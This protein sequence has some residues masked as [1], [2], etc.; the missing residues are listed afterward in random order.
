MTTKRKRSAGFGAGWILAVCFAARGAAADAEFFETRIRPVLAE[1]CYECHS[2]SAS[3]LKGGLRVDA[4]RELLKGGN[5]GPAVVPGE[6]KASLLL[7]SIEHRDADLAMPPKKPKLS[8]ATLADFER[9]IR[10]GAKWP[11]ST[12]GGESSPANSAKK[13][14]F[15]LE[16][17]KQKQAWL[18]R[19]P[20]APAIPAVQNSQWPR[21]P[22]D[23]FVL[24][25]LEEADLQPAAPAD[26]RTWLRRAHFAITGL[27]PSRNEIAAFLADRDGR[28]GR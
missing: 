28:S 8:G 26:D 20:Q 17:R 23:F 22:E 25:R 19:I 5:S 10:D 4:R 11:E 27:P 3:K 1:H 14:G 7:A 12:T 21:S 9:R 24:Q 18:W 13:G 2:A 15:D 6:P 16:E